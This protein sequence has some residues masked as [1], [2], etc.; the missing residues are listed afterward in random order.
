M[1][2][3]ERGDHLCQALR[4]RLQRRSGSGTLLDESGI[5]LGHLIQSAHGVADFADA[6]EAAAVRSRD[7]GLLAL[8]AHARAIA[9]STAANQPSMVLS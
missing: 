8:M 4:L 3:A 1:P 5:L 9:V 7:P 2:Q 6:C